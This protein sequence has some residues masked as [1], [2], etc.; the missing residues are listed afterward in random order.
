MLSAEERSEIEA[1]APHYPVREAL[2][3]DALKVVQKHRGWIS[4]ESV[5]EIAAYLGMSHTDL[6][7]VATFYNL[8][9]RK[10]V[11][12]HVMYICDSVSCWIM[13]S[14]RVCAAL[15]EHHGLEPG[16]TTAD[17]RFTLLPIVCLGCCDR[18]PAMLVDDDLHAPVDDRNLD[19]ILERYR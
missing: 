17:G 6:D 4:D 16:K 11:G 14:D 12:R 3:I 1:E 19:A 13:G 7:S 15:R 10:P 9:H 5:A 18:A 8:I 2:A